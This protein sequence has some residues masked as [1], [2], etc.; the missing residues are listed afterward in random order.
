MMQVSESRNATL[1]LSAASV[2]LAA[3]MCSSTCCC[4]A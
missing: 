4:A 3:M 1:T 2:G